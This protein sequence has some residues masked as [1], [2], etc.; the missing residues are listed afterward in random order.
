MRKP[1]L[2]K[3]NFGNQ[4]LANIGKDVDTLNLPFHFVPV[5]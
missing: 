5:F 2:V 3:C 1:F 4:W